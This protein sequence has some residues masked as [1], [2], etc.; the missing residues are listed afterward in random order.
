MIETLEEYWKSFH[1]SQNTALLT[2]S[3]PS[4]VIKNLGIHN[5]FSILNKEDAHILTIGVGMGKLERDIHSWKIKV[6]S[7]DITPEAFKCIEGILH[8]QY[9]SADVDKLPTDTF[10]LA[11]SY[12]VACHQSDQVLQ[13][14]I[15]EILRALKPTGIFALLVAGPG[16]NPH[17]Y[18]GDEMDHCR[19]GSKMRTP[20]EIT[21]LVKVS[22]GD[23]KWVGEPLG[24]CTSF[25]MSYPVHIIKH[26]SE[27]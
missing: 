5:I 1:T 21:E 24:G 10:D 19:R 16:D 8:N 4:A 6:S 3:N 27:K 26:T 25:I 13:I 14:Q 11:I 23:V 7:L 9:L 18:T 15:Q 20:Q 12:M 2:D 22:G 17:V